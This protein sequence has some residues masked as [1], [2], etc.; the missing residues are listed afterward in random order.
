M[1][2]MFREVFVVAPPGEMVLAGKSIEAEMAALGVVA[3]KLSGIGG[4]ILLLGLAG[5]WMLA[6]RFIRPIEDISLAAAKIAAGDLSQRIEAPDSQT[7]LGALANVLNSTF[8]Q[9]DAAFEQQRA[10][11]ADAAHELRT[12]ISVILTNTQSALTRE[13]TGAEYRETIQS[14]ERAAQ[15]MRRLTESLLEMAR[16]DAGK[17]L[18]KHLTF[19]LSESVR[20]CVELLRP[21]AVESEVELLCQLPPVSCVGDPNRI[22]QVIVNLLANAIQYSK[23]NGRVHIMTEWQSGTAILKVVDNGSGINPEDLPHI[24]RRFY[25]GDKSRSSGT[26]QGGLGLAI[27]KAI[28]DAHGGKITVSSQPEIGSTFTVYLPSPE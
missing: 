26:G 25:R 8:A 27:T 15:R 1:R 16:L 6:S 18:V 21:M 28:I 10:F 2:E 7:E 13:R 4:V 22:G 11:T 9:L 14:C 19:N 17:S 23:R 3:W 5:G 12:P 24:Y 20:E